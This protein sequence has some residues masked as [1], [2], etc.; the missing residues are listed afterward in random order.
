MS[1]PAKAI[2]KQFKDR[3]PTTLLT[4]GIIVSFLDFMALYL[5]A[6]RD[7]VLHIDGGIGL[8]QNYGLFSTLL[9]NAIS[10]YVAKKF[11]EGVCQIESSKA[12]ANIAPIKAPLSTL[13][14]MIGIRQKY[15]LK[16]Y[17]L[18]VAGLFYWVSN[19]AFHVLG[20]PEVRWGH[21]VFDSLDHPLTFVASRIHNLYTFLFI[22]PVVVY[23]LICST[24][25][26]TRAIAAASREGA[27]KYDLLNPDRRG[28]YGFVDKVTIAFN[29]TVGLIYIQFSLH[30]LT[31]ARIATEHVIGCVILM[32][33]L[34]GG[35]RMFLGQIYAT[36]RTLRI[37]SL[38]T[39][40]D[41]V[42]KDDTL[43][44]EILKYC[45]ERRIRT[46]SIVNFAVKSVA[47]LTPAI[48]KYWPD[49]TRVLGRV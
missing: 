23:V 11:Y 10:L 27:L 13:G 21:K 30:V 6:A 40:K 12:V 1:N 5:A 41:K 14:D 20:N 28:G 46:S 9:G 15:R 39:I 2:A 37:K 25:Q 34:I 32:L 35:N 29:L 3:S 44:F 26:L 19:V 38:N 8:L 33:L 22:M 7:G 16:I 45:Y 42:Y 17:P 31:F 43:S 36:I 48:V 47:F 18:I 4:L 49:I 24:I